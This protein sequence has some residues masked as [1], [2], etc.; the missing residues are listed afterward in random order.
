MA[1]LCNPHISSPREVN[2]SVHIY[3]VL[4]HMNE[5]CNWSLKLLYFSKIPSSKVF[6]RIFFLRRREWKLIQHP[7]VTSREK[8]VIN[9]HIYLGQSTLPITFSSK[10]NRNLIT[11]LKTVKNNKEIAHPV[12]KDGRALKHRS[13]P[14]F[15]PG[16]GMWHVLTSKSFGAS[17][18]GRI[19]LHYHVYHL[20]QG[21]MHKKHFSLYCYFVFIS[22]ILK[23]PIAGSY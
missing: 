23:Y 9:A 12:S 16:S 19:S 11:T 21:Q 2:R 18:A 14:C 8:A 1:H 13:L 17:K 22:P 15:W 20:R 4:V 7:Q 6:H 3:R 10:R 5:L